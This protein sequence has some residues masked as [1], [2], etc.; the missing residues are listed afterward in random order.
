MAVL[1]EALYWFE[2]AEWY[3]LSL[4]ADEW[5]M[6]MIRGRVRGIIT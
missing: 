4:L 2:V 1:A 6:C 3:D 5:G